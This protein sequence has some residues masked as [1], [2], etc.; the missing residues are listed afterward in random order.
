MLRHSRP[1]FSR[2]RG[3][4]NEDVVNKYRPRC[5]PTVTRTPALTLTQAQTTISVH[6][7]QTTDCVQSCKHART[8][9]RTHVHTYTQ[10][11]DKHTYAPVPDLRCAGPVANWWACAPH[12]LT[13]YSMTFSPHLS[14]VSWA[15]LTF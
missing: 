12:Q 14:V 5:Q 1:L 11:H 6:M 8:H 10:T 2:G 4:V 3:D 9:I 13:Y 7:Y 15:G